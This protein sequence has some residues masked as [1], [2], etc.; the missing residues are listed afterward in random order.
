MGAEHQTNWS[1]RSAIGQLSYISRNTR[2]DIEMAVHQCAKY[3]IDPKHAHEQAVKRIVRYLLGTKNKGI[4][5]KPNEK[6]KEL[7]CYVDADFAGA[8]RKD[9]INEDP[10]SV[11]S[12]TVFVIKYANGPIAWASKLQ[13]DTSLSTTEDEYIA[14][15]TATR[16]IIPMRQIILEFSAIIDISGAKLNL[17]FTI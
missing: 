2:P 11:R 10:V 5:I 14:L 1:Y 7:E 15:S 16:E 8:Y 3:Q 13:T 17:K 6:V 9:D 12:R 4:L